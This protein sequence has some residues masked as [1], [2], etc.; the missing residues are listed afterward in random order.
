VIRQPLYA[1]LSAVL[2]AVVL[3]FVADRVMFLK[4]AQHTTG[5]VVSVTARNDRCGGRRSRHSCTRFQAAV[6]YSPE[7]GGAS[8][9]LS[10]S[11]G[12]AYGYDQPVSRASYAVGQRVPVV[13]DPAHPEKSYEDS[14]TGVWGTPIMAF[15][16]QIVFFFTSLTEPRRRR[17]E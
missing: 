13:Y 6:R 5:S 3:W 2:L 9:S 1:M 4:R 10:L 7:G 16:F 8:Y 14:F 11:G 17:W 12:D 15:V